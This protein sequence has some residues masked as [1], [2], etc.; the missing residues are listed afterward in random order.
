MV[1]FQDQ[2]RGVA[3]KDQAFI[4]DKYHRVSGGDRHDQKGFGLGLSYVR[5]IME[6]HSGFIKVIS[7]LNKGCRFDL[8]IPG[9]S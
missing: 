1:L 4:F 3:K 9:K 7:D 5:M 2:G 6:R 8:Y